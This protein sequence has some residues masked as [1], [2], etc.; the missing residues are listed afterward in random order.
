MMMMMLIRMLD[1]EIVDKLMRKLNEYGEMKFRFLFQFISL[2]TES[3]NL[4]SLIFLSLWLVSWLKGKKLV[5]LDN[6]LV[7]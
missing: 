3:S 6:S 5:G 2:E 7:S 1:D 4:K